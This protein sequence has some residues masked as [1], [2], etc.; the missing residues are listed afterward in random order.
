MVDVH[1]GIAFAPRGEELDEP[2]DHLLL[3]VEGVRP[4]LVVDPLARLVS[5]EQA[6]EEHQVV[7]RRPERVALEVEEDV[8]VVGLGQQ[9]EAVPVDRVFASP[10]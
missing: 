7:L 4:A 10:R 8:A 1:V 6:R 5:V 3:L 9:L 2:L